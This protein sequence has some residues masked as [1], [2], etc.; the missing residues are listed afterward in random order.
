MQRR[1][2]HKAYQP[3]A[4]V[5]NVRR[6]RIYHRRLENEWKGL[7]AAR[8][9]KERNEIVNHS[10][11]IRI[12]CQE[13]A[14][15]EMAQVGRS[16]SET[17]WRC[18]I[19]GGKEGSIERKDRCY[20]WR[21]AVEKSSI[22]EQWY[23]SVQKPNHYEWIHGTSQNFHPWK[24]VYWQLIQ[25][26][27]TTRPWHQYTKSC[28]KLHPNIRKSKLI[29][30]LSEVAKE[31]PDTPTSITRGN[32]ASMPILPRQI[33]SNNKDIIDY[34]LEKQLRSKVIWFRTGLNSK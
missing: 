11:S 34:P 5:Y 32:H 28:R 10:A 23:A 19:Q 6:P 16:P 22:E 3:E 33:T 9:E 13:I 8:R 24:S 2:Y 31:G 26:T 14:A 30:R 20:D 18:W 15:K 21:I 27:F 29:K 17:I 4:Y 7:Q 25:I 1:R 12:R